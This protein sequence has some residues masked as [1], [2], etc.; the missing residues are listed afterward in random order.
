MM[1]ESWDLII[2]IA[3]PTHILTGAFAALV[4]FPAQIFLPK[5]ALHRRIGRWAVWLTVVIAASGAALLLSPMFNQLLEQDLGKLTLGAMSFGAESYRPIFRDR[6]TA[7]LFFV[8]IDVVL[9]YLVVTGAGTWSRLARGSRGRGFPPRRVDV[10]LTVA[11]VLVT[12]IEVVF[13]L[14]DLQSN[15]VFARL[16]LTYAPAIFIVAG[17]DVWTWTGGGRGRRWW[18]LI[19]ALK[20]LEAW[21]ALIFAVMLRYALDDQALNDHEGA[22]LLALSVAGL[23][24]IGV[25]AARNVRRPQRGS[26]SA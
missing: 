8:W 7:P 10:A 20:L 12:A 18:W 25:Y 6:T 19:H 14:H 22:I 13:A 15:P 17:I 21:R 1:T 11:V 4:V 3:L 9:L 16:I 26:H 2:R 24:A 5:H 23:V